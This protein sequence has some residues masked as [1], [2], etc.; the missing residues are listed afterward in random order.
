MATQAKVTAV[1][2][3]KDNASSTLNKVSGNFKTFAV[4]L[5]AVVAGAALVGKGLKMALDSAA[6]AQVKI[7]SMDATLKAMG[8]TSVETRNR[9]LNASAAFTKLGLDDEE[10]AK[11]MAILYQRTKDVGQAMK[12]TSLAADLARA[13]NI[14]LESSTK[15]VSMALSGNGRALMQ[16]GI[17]IKDAATPLEAL[18]ELQKAVGGQ[19]E[20]FSK[21]FIGQSE[22]LKMTFDDFLQTI[23]D[24]L[25]PLLTAAL[26]SLSDF[27]NFIPTLVENVGAFFKTIDDN[28]A[29]V[30]TFRE[31]WD[32]VAL[33]FQNTLMPALEELWQALLPLSPYLKALGQ[34]IGATL[35]ASILLLAGTLTLITNIIVG[36]MTALTK[37]TTFIVT[38]VSS[39]IE[40]VRGLFESWYNIMVKIVDILSKISL[41]NIASGVSG[42]IKGAA[43]AVGSLLKKLPSFDVGG[44]VPGPVGAPQLAV[45]HGGEYVTPVGKKAPGGASIN[46]SI[47]GNTISSNLDVRDIADQVGHEIMRALK[48]TQQI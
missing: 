20:A 16:Y 23:G 33:N 40:Y 43:G 39:A 10:A 4:S 15:L 44:Y 9:I 22:V 3:A 7:A 28:T 2:E 32:L 31:A 38:V 42:A 24:R 11:S 5:G 37:L 6:D 27:I 45:V 12:L 17:N 41:S 34:I 47:S 25:I 13:K 29:I 8:D 1:I 36:V 18:E 14:D 19:A 30:Q 26:R 48:L 46:V 35:V 21:T